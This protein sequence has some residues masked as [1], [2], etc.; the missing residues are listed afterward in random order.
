MNKH[1][2]SI[3]ILPAS[4]MHAVV[5]GEELVLDVDEE[6]VEDESMVLDEVLKVE[7][8][9]DIVEDELKLPVEDRSVHRRWA[10]TDLSLQ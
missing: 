5:L 4:S 10:C 2:C 3:E 9:E 7:L 6:A 8:S 1:N